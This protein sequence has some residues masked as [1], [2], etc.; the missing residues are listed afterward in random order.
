MPN[1][2]CTPVGAVI[3]VAPPNASMSQKRVLLLHEDRLLANFFRDR[4]E[5]EN[6]TVETAQDAEAGL[7]IAREGKPDAVVMDSV[8]PGVQLG[9]LIPQLRELGG[10]QP[11]PVIV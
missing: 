7:K 5:N 1:Y 2:R 3:R 10:Q 6:F 9:N 11:L 8:L 4:L